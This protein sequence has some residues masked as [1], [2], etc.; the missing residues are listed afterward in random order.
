VGTTWTFTTGSP[1]NLG[2]T[3]QGTIDT[4][5]SASDKQ[6]LTLVNNA[7]TQARA[8]GSGQY[9]A[10]SALAWHCSLEQAA[11]GH[12]TD[13]ANNNFFSH[14]GS[15]GLN[16]GQRISA[17]GN[18]WRAWG[19]NIAAGYTTA[20]SAMAGWL[21]SSGHCANIMNAGFTEMGAASATNPGSD[22]GIYWTQ[23]FADR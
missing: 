11:A 18:P 21:G 6:M 1:F 5:M 14:T 20:E 19:E 2:P 4:C 16:A 9:P 13:M 22:Y 3:D 15:D 12:S 7:R 8:C 23:A 10:V 17:T